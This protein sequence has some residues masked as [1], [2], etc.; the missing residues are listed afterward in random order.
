MSPQ[1]KKVLA[2]ELLQRQLHVGD[3]FL[4]IYVPWPSYTNA[5]RY[6]HLKED[7][8]EYPAVVVLEKRDGQQITSI[9]GLHTARANAQEDAVLACLDW[10][11]AHGWGEDFMAALP[12]GSLPEKG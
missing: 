12:D 11:K 6:P 8:T 1:D 2:F 3:A 9:V 5:K 7:V 4:R 10:I